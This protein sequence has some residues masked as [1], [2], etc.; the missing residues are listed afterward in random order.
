VPLF[1]DSIASVD[2]AWS[3]DTNAKPGEEKKPEFKKSPEYK[4]FK[5]VLK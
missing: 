2:G 4:R 3:I 5:K 1:G